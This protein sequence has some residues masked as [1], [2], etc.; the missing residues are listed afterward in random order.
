[1][2]LLAS[3]SPWQNDNVPK[4]RVATMG[5]SLR[6]TVKLRPNVGEDYDRYATQENPAALG[7]TIM[8]SIEDT[9]SRNDETNVKINTMLNK[10]T[11]FSD[12]GKMADFNPPPPPESVY[13]NQGQMVP[14]KNTLVPPS[15]PLVNPLVPPS[16]Q[17]TPTSNPS[18]YYKP[19]ETKSY[20]NYAQVYPDKITDIKSNTGPYYAKMGIGQSQDKLAEKLNYMVHLLEEMQMEKTNHITEEFILYSLLGVFM[21]YLVDGFAQTGKYVR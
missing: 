1:M 4:K 15:N 13:R 10:I 6:K 8:P 16:R 3:A 20:S 5:D 12:S 17:P 19:M 14:P 18:G 21:I 11:G 9:K 7:N 2:S